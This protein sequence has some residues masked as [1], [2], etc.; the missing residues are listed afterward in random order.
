MLRTMHALTLLAVLASTWAADAPPTVATAATAVPSAV[1]AK[2]TKLTVLGADDGGAAGLSYAWT[3]VGPAAVTFSSTNN[4]QAGRSLTA[5]FAAPG[6]YDLTATITDGVGQQVASTVSVTVNATLSTLT[7]S[8]TSAV[9]NPLAT[10]RYIAT[11]KNQFGAVMADL[12]LTW[13][14]TGNGAVDAT[15]VFTAA[16]LPGPASVS[17]AAET[18]TATATIRVNAAPTLDAPVATTTPVV[19]DK[20]AIFTTQGADDASADLL[21][22][23]WSAHGP[24]AVSFSPRSS[25]AGETTTATFR[26]SG[27]Y[28][29]TATVTDKEGLSVASSTVVRVEQTPTGL[30]IAPRHHVVV[31]PGMS[32]PFTATVKDQFN[33]LMIA[34]P[35]VTWM[36]TS[37][38][39]AIDAAGVYTAAEPAGPATIAAS[40]GA[41]TGSVAL[42]VNATPTVAA[43]VSTDT[44]VVTG[45][46]AVFT[47]QGDDDASVDLLT[48]T[49]SATGPKAVSFAPRRSTAGETT[50]ATFHAAGSY[51]IMATI[52]DKEGLT[53]SSTT[54]VT[55]NQTVTALV[56]SPSTNVVINPGLTKPFVATT[57]DQFNALMS[58]QPVPTWTVTAGSG[59]IG[60]DGIYLAGEPG[61]VTV[62]ATSGVAAGSVTLRVN[63]APV[64]SGPVTITP[65][66]DG[67]LAVFSASG[68]D[69]ESVD[70]LKYTWSATGPKGVGFAPRSG[71]TAEE[72]VA[73]FA[74]SGIYVITVNARDRQGL[75]ANASIT[76]QVRQTATS[77]AISPTTAVVNPKASRTFAAALKDQFGASLLTQPGFTWSAVNGA[78]DGTGRFIAPPDPGQASVTVLAPDT[79]YA[80]N[81]TIRI[82][83]P[84]T[85][86]VPAEMIGS[87]P[88]S[89]RT[90]VL[91]ALGADDGGESNIRY[92]WSVVGSMASG[93][94]FSGAV[95]NTTAAQYMNATVPRPGVYPFRVLIRDA[96]GLSVMSTVAVMVP[97]QAPMVVSMTTS[98]PVPLTGVMAEL[99]VQAQDDDDM[100]D[101]SYQWTASGPAP[102]SFASG[103]AATTVAT[104]VQAGTYVL[105]ATVTDAAGQDAS[106]NMDL[107]VTAHPVSLAVTPE[108]ASIAAGT[109]T[110]L[111]AVITDQF[112][113]A[114]TEGQSVGWTATGPLSVV[115]QGMS[116][117]ITGAES[118]GS[119]VVT[120][121][122]D[123]LSAQAQITVV[124]QVV[125]TVV[126]LVATELETAEQPVGQ[127]GSPAELTVQRSGPTAHDLLVGYAIDGTAD[128]GSDYLTLSGVIII[129]AG[130]TSAV[131]QIHALEDQV[132]EP[133]ETVGICLRDGPGYRLG[134]SVSATVLI[135]AQSEVEPALVDW[136]AS[137]ARLFTADGQ[138][139]V[140][141]LL[142]KA[143][144][145][146][147]TVSYAVAG[148][149]VAALLDE[150]GNPIPAQGDY[151]A[152]PGTMLIPAGAVFCDLPITCLDTGSSSDPVTVELTLS[153]GTGYA[154]GRRAITTVTIVP[155]AADPPLS[156]PVVTPGDG[157][158]LA[159]RTVTMRPVP[160]TA[161]VW[162]T[163]TT[164]G[165]V[166]AD[167]VP[168]QPA[169]MRGTGDIS[170]SAVG[171][172]RIK[173]VSAW[174]TTAGWRT[175]AITQASLR[176]VMPGGG[177]D[178]S[179]FTGGQQQTS[180]VSPASLE[181]TLPIGLSTQVI[182][183]A[184]VDGE[185]VATAPA[186]VSANG[187]AYGNVQL[188]PRRPTTVRA[189]L[190]DPSGTRHDGMSTQV[191]WIPI[192]MLADA[193]PIVIR[194]GDML[195]LSAGSETSSSY[196][197]SMLQGGPAVPMLIDSGTG[198]AES[199][200]A[201]VAGIPVMMAY[202]EHGNFTASVRYADAS[203]PLA[204]RQVTVVSGRFTDPG[205]DLLA[206]VGIPRPIGVNLSPECPGA[207]EAVYQASTGSQPTAGVS[208]LQ[209]VVDDFASEGPFGPWT[210]T[211]P[212]V[213]LR[214]A[215]LD[216]LV[217]GIRD[218]T[219]FKLV[220]EPQAAAMKPN[221]V[222][223]LRMDMV[224]FIAPER[225]STRRTK[226]GAK[227]ASLSYVAVTDKTDEAGYATGVFGL[228]QTVAAGS[229][230]VAYPT[231]FDLRQ[232]GV[233]GEI[234]LTTDEIVGDKGIVW[235]GIESYDVTVVVEAERTG[236]H[237]HPYWIFSG[238]VGDYGYDEYEYTRVE[239]EGYLD[240]N[241]DWI[242][243]FVYYERW[244]W[245]WDRYLNPVDVEPPATGEVCTTNVQLAIPAEPWLSRLTVNPPFNLLSSAQ[246]VDGRNSLSMSYCAAP[247]IAGL[248][249]QVSRPENPPSYE[250]SDAFPIF[251]WDKPTANYP[252]YSDDDGSWYWGWSWD[253]DPMTV[254]P[255]GA[256]VV[257][258]ANALCE[259]SG[260]NSYIGLSGPIM[261]YWTTDGYNGCLFKDY[262][263]NFPDLVNSGRF[264]VSGSGGASCSVNDSGN[265]YSPYKLVSGPVK[266]DYPGVYTLVMSG[267]N[268]AFVSPYYDLSF[269]WIEWAGTPGNV[270]VYV[271]GEYVSCANGSV[272]VVS[273]GVFSEEYLPAGIQLPATCD[274]QV[275]LRASNQRL[276]LFA[277]AATT[278][279][280]YD[281]QGRIAVQV[282][283][284]YD[285]DAGTDYASTVSVGLRADFRRD[286][287]VRLIAEENDL[288]VT[289]G[290]LRFE[291]ITGGM[292]ISPAGGTDHALPGGVSVSALSGNVVVQ[293]PVVVRG[294][295]VP[296]LVLTYNAHEGFDYGFG[297]GWRTN[298]DMQLA[299][300][301]LINETGARVPR[302]G[303]V[304]GPAYVNVS[305]ELLRGDGRALSFD[306]SGLLSS[307]RFIGSDRV[308]R[309]ARNSNGAVTTV[310]D[311]WDAAHPLVLNPAQFSPS[312]MQGMAGLVIK[313]DGTWNVQMDNAPMS[314][315]AFAAWTFTYHGDDHAYAMKSLDCT[316]ASVPVSGPMPALHAD[317]TYDGDS[318]PVCRRVAYGGGT[319]PVS[320]WDFSP[321]TGTCT[322][323]DPL[324][325]TTVWAGT[326]DFWTSLTDAS[327]VVHRRKLAANLLSSWT[328]I[329]AESTGH[330]EDLV[331]TTLAGGSR[332]P[333]RTVR[334]LDELGTQSV[335]E[336]GWDEQASVPVGCHWLNRITVRD[337]DGIDGASAPVTIE[338]RTTYE[339]SGPAT[340]QVKTSS[341]PDG[342]GEQYQRTGDHGALTAIV[343]RRRQSWAVSAPLGGPV[344]V[345]RSPEGH[346]A[347][348]TRSAATPDRPTYVRRMDGQTTKDIVYDPYGRVV[349]STDAAG[350]T[351]TTIT[352]PLGQVIQTT[353]ET[354]R[355]TSFTYDGL[356]RLKTTSVQLPVAEP[357]PTGAPSSAGAGPGT[358]NVPGESWEYMVV[359]G[360]RLRIERRRAGQTVTVR[361][362][363]GLGHLV[364]SVERHTRGL[365]GGSG[366][367]DAVTTWDYDAA[368][369]LERVVSP[370]GGVTTWQ[371]DRA[372]RV[373]SQTET[374]DGMTRFIG[375]AWNILGW[376]LRQTDVNGFVTAWTYDRNGSLV[377]TVNP[378]GGWRLV[379]RDPSGAETVAYSNAGVVARTR[380]DKDGAVSAR[381]DQTGITAAESWSAAT[382]TYRRIVTDGQG[383]T[384]AVAP[385]STT[386]DTTWATRAVVQTTR[387]QGL[388]T[389]QET[390]IRRA[391]GSV[392][393]S[394][395]T[396]RPSVVTAMAPTGMPWLQMQT[397]SVP[398]GAD[399]DQTVTL[400]TAVTIRSEDGRPEQTTD[401]WGVTRAG[402]PDLITGD[403]DAGTV[404]QQGQTL[405]NEV[406]E[407]DVLGRVLKQRQIIPATA[408]QAEQRL[409]TERTF[410]GFGRIGSETGPDQVTTVYAYDAGDRLIGV[411]R[412]TQPW[413]TKV[414][415]RLGNL[416]SATD[417]M[418]RTVT[419]QYDAI[420]R[421]ISETRGDDTTW[422]VYDPDLM[423]LLRKIEPGNRITSFAYDDHGRLHIVTGPDGRQVITTYDALGRRA[424]MEFPTV[425]G[426]AGG[427]VEMW[428]YDG[429]TNRFRTHVD[430]LGRVTTY[431]YTTSGTL[432][433]VTVRGSDQA[434]LADVRPGMTVFDVPQTDG[435]VRQ[436]SVTESSASGSAARIEVR[437]FDAQGRLLSLN[438]PGQGG[439]I[440]YVYDAAG[441]LLGRGGL[442][443]R[444]DDIGRLQLVQSP[445]MQMELRYDSGTGMLSSQNFSN[446]IARTVQHDD[447]GWIRQVS[448]Q[449]QD[450]STDW[451]VIRDDQG[452]IVTVADS[453]GTTTYQYRDGRVLQET[454]S[455]QWS[456]IAVF[457][458]DTAGN[459]VKHDRYVGVTTQSESFSGSGVPAMIVPDPG[460]GEW[461][462]QSG[463]LV[464]G[465]G[466]TAVWN[467]G[468]TDRFSCPNIGWAA[469]EDG[470]EVVLQDGAQHEIGIMLEVETSPGLRRC[471]L[472]VGVPGA[473]VELGQ[474]PWLQ[475]PTGTLA[476]VDLGVDASG[477]LSAWLQSGVGGMRVSVG[478]TTALEGVAGARLRAG[479]GGSSFD[480]LRWLTADQQIQVERT[481]DERNRFTE[482]TTTIRYAD[483]RIPVVM[484]RGF[485]YDDGG[486]LLRID[487][488][489]A[490]SDV[491]TTE[492]GYDALGRM[493]SWHSGTQSI[494]YT[495]GPGGRIPVSETSAGVTRT[496]RADD[497]G[498]LSF[499]GSTFGSVGGQ[500]WWTD[501][502]NWPSIYAID[503]QGH[504][505]GRI[506]DLGMIGSSPWQ[507][508]ISWL[509]RR[510]YSA[511]GVP[512]VKIPVLP[513][514]GS[515]D[516]T[517]IMYVEGL[518]AAGPGYRGGWCDA[519][520]GLMRFGA[521]HYSPDLGAFTQSDPAMAGG[522]WYAYADGDPVNKY[523]PSGLR[524]IVAY[525]AMDDFN[526]WW[527]DNGMTNWG[528]NYQW[529]ETMGQEGF[530]VAGSWN[531]LKDFQQVMMNYSEV[532][533]SKALDLS[534]MN[535]K[536]QMFAL[537]V[538]DPE[539]TFVFDK[540]GW[541]LS[542]D[543]DAPSSGIAVR[544]AVYPRVNGAVQ[545]VGG[546]AEATIGAAAVATPEPTMVT[547]VVGGIAIAHGSDNMAAGGNALIFG[548]P[549][550]TFTSRLAQGSMELMGANPRLAMQ[551]GEGTN[552]LLSLGTMGWGAYRYFSAPRTIQPLQISQPP[553][554]YWHGSKEGVAA[555]QAQ[556]INFTDVAG[557]ETRL[558]ATT[559]APRNLL[560]DLLIGGNTNLAL[561]S[562][563]LVSKGGMESVYALRASEAGRFQRAWG[564]GYS[565]NPYQ[566]YKGAMGQYYFDVAPRTFAQRMA[567]LGR[568]GWITGAAAGGAY[569]LSEATE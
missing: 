557:A 78:I 80:A 484:H 551:V 49:W 543:G 286:D 330:T 268:H 138:V 247:R 433:R 293:V 244:L 419:R 387:V 536:E 68:T 255:Q 42:R 430:R 373:V 454:H 272:S 396:G 29:I 10:Q 437:R 357:P 389:G 507:G 363:D 79:P 511:F 124:P 267:Q 143:L 464:G 514:D 15:G 421:Q 177:S 327:G 343:D 153:D 65:S 58:P 345:T 119:A 540:N 44:P 479:A 355:I 243:D 439:A 127:P 498:V 490:G 206:H 529:G 535:E 368:G 154:V 468:Q 241:G 61:S 195:L 418:G 85:V 71:T 257:A 307:I 423:V 323:T 337:V 315:D 380:L 530:Y 466:A 522:N 356:L 76:V 38:P 394:I 273:Q 234:S 489:G 563:F 399:A 54:T 201:A 269:W 541:R 250:W 341:G 190:T 26:A 333:I 412:G 335:T 383:A 226:E 438:V 477:G 538:A 301:Y 90:F 50:T 481:V 9:V 252:T 187:H 547:K 382:G 537:M 285:Y 550:Q 111:Q 16:D 403:V 324:G 182:L 322:V 183:Q 30:S 461:S 474:S 384:D 117:Q 3:A 116:V 352:G 136:Q 110:V 229:S 491:V 406:L 46:T 473:P 298:W 137:A 482:E 462:V 288:H 104:F 441:K 213:I 189:V 151:L 37:G 148:T 72:T 407:R 88:A 520:T 172:Y 160:E 193:T 60:S 22:Y 448:L 348:M 73:T 204:T 280:P 360:H 391:D 180:R 108:V 227:T 145:S 306:G 376:R 485:Q 304:T 1:T 472:S 196:G 186:T 107:I 455:G 192:D 130:A 282:Q 67:K 470:A 221:T 230:Q 378:A 493:T 518:A 122:L 6:S 432:R 171:D 251:V 369:R 429:D 393:Q 366:Y 203:T 205:S 35:D 184:L 413:A 266:Y 133:M 202:P 568:A 142:S 442:D 388:V 155:S 242:D 40:V 209:L 66:I 554:L 502:G 367:Q 386:L 256:S 258:T 392:S 100:S 223:L 207:V 115:D 265:E 86:V 48:Y 161:A 302:S 317:F 126:T 140:R 349:A 173:A 416:V 426:S 521:R 292:G 447:A 77:L 305:G 451:T 70:Y 351:S 560:T 350:T 4:T 152:V 238:I 476:R 365:E 334:T 31:N 95:Q 566:W 431:D 260:G 329:G 289:N 539:H 98:T 43:A 277:G 381:T 246:S 33:A 284:G 533:P 208:S 181:L 340:G 62:T 434:I 114:V 51:D 475:L 545:M 379:G 295:D 415:D 84:P 222:A 28:D 425:S 414:Y 427:S 555:R 445:R 102:V 27:S 254:V 297:P 436:T 483:D 118:G 311:S 219:P 534:T 278:P 346:D 440:N 569:A 300:S 215:T 128:N 210:L 169:A 332:L 150:E 63:S 354:G 542:N 17:V 492:M 428:T 134:A 459:Q 264:P 424:R 452:R 374:A 53:T 11:A 401:P 159:P 488:E 495:W 131:I 359:P 106:M 144:P 101:L 409:V 233:A 504:V 270:I 59:T 361:D 519:A 165:S 158:W 83:A 506:G 505:A 188:D 259:R 449:G 235:M 96:Q 444:Y 198:S 561:R 410:D 109:S 339:T 513:A 500:T 338:S 402:L 556:G 299:G 344:F 199:A 175:S 309:I 422:F 18:K 168:G 89:M 364:R 157:V 377:R 501:D 75:S 167:P 503:V 362:L 113:H 129:P 74:A 516:L 94:V 52:T 141:A 179:G 200:L 525:G 287:A 214:T 358:V 456:G 47:V 97:D 318:Y 146:D 276:Q 395:G 212:C 494:E 531:P 404:V 281:E 121:T 370:S 325:T 303:P 308:W 20:T 465:P 41:A 170:L 564:T 310:T 487:Q 211:K 460:Q 248:T 220:Q 14:A 420:G 64:L 562:P 435:A 232:Q 245:S 400:A 5:Y 274:H 36:V 458:Y 548:V 12:P 166:P 544:N 467:V 331:E 225:F 56:V 185:V 497:M 336:F 174:R 314:N 478:V 91:H 443:Y 13:S 81:A 237:G 552:A 523:D 312:R 2:T 528:G 319:T 279:S 385:L 178:S 23:T 34:Q 19:T 135:S 163:M 218:I 217:L 469:S 398:S 553:A 405:Y 321:G 39:G 162:F 411:R 57:R 147:L 486:Q 453:E 290:E 446:G 231:T 249:L 176:V 194:A 125:E 471:R 262:P 565:W 320:A 457:G 275:K 139:A 69:D 236:Q 93:V 524:A 508:H 253:S 463:R 510:S 371:Y 375:T 496:Y 103:D 263:P 32:T 397:M 532:Y 408:D 546:A 224:P 499:A 509:E 25:T 291:K 21:T 372:G 417:P 559:R 296:D 558:W 294:P 347:S 480:D 283:G 24:A 271:P 132:A 353:D 120:A 87:D 216:H 390:I 240:A 99:S 326:A 515:M 450:V 512:T 105:T 517:G 197:G 549:T 8:P 7:I 112:G 527:K 164:D 82:N 228:S 55:V 149:A 526:K 316:G 45:T 123:G 313:G 156:V 191:T 328:Q 92:T 239:E 342:L 567:E 261:N